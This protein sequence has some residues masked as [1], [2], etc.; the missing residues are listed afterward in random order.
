M[1]KTLNFKTLKT[2]LQLSLMVVSIF[3]FSQTNP[4]LEMTAGASNPTGN[5]PVLTTS[6]NFQKN[7][8]NPSG[9]TFAAYTPA[10]SATYTISNS[11]YTTTV[12]NSTTN[13]GYDLGAGTLI[14]PTMDGNGAPVNANFTSST[15]TA[16][17]GMSVTSNNSVRFNIMTY[18]LRVNALA[19]NGI[20][21]M[22]DLTIT[23]NRPVNNPVIHIGGL[24]GTS[25]AGLGYAARLDLVSSNVPTTSL[26]LTRLSGNN[27]TGFQVTGLSIFNGATPI[28][29]SGT[30]SGSGSV[31]IN[32]NGITSLTFTLSIR[33]DGAVTSTTA[34][35]N[36]NTHTG[37]GDTFTIGISNLESDLAVTKTVDNATPTEGSNIV[38]TVTASNLGASNN[39]NVTVNDLLP[40]GYTYVS[41]TA[42]T[43]TYVP[44]TGVWT[45]GNLNDQANATL[46]ITAI[47]N[48]TGN[49]TNTATIST[50]SGIADPNTTNNTASVSTTPVITDSDGDGVPD[51]LDLDDDNDGILDTTEGQCINTSNPSTDGFDSPLVATVNGNNIQSVNPYNG[52]GTETG[53]ANAFNVIRVNG[54]GYASGPDNAQSGTQY[55]DI[56]ASSTYVYKD[57][58]LTTPTVFSASAWFANR[59]SSNG[60]YAPWSTKI[61]IRNETTGI[62]VAQGN[63]INFTSSISD[64]I[65]YNSSINSVALP[66][67]TYRIRMFVGD[68]GHLDS[69]SYCFSKDTD[70]D[71]TPDH[72]DLDSDNDGCADAIEGGDN[73]TAGMLDGIGRINVAANGTTTPVVVDANGVPVVT[74]TSSI[75][76]VD[77][78]A[79][80]QTVGSSANASV[81]GCYCYKP[82]QT[83]GTILDTNHGI[84]ALGRAGADNSNWPMVRKGAWTVLEAKT[85]GFVVNRLTDAQV[86]AIPSADLREGMMVYNITQDCLQINIDGTATG[87]RCFNTQTCPDL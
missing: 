71:G 16:G 29:A 27:A 65:W 53:G 7:T 43:G 87:W 21:A 11:R 80:G 55:I 44:G 24:G 35:A 51:S 57:I 37:S 61:E 9:N 13:I 74:N 77:G 48:A 6:I 86:S 47:V 62:T 63:T 60:G 25:S 75:Y 54:A 39:S 84:T 18:P 20:H 32:G 83:S 70:G 69:I 72:L 26:S 5:G 73:V 4:D 1:N 64:E 78:Q 76:N 50:T 68:F 14:F 19:T 28:R 30:N 17:T 46:T 10:L 49:F 3:V 58:I 42:S 56:N 85:K 79:Q 22:S 33:G 23:F 82:A 41:H 40:S 8:N 36:T 2:L 45:I 15:S 67:G 81:N 34:W 12:N 52:W 38:F 31:R 59:E 66:A